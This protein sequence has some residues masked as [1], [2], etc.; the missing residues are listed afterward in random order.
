MSERVLL[1]TL[2]SECAR[3]LGL[4]EAEWQFHWDVLEAK[5]LLGK[6]LTFGCRE[7]GRG[8]YGL[9]GLDLDPTAEAIMIGVLG[10]I[11]YDI[12]KHGPGWLRKKDAWESLN[13]QIGEISESGRQLARRVLEWAQDNLDSFVRKPAH[14]PSTLQEGDQQ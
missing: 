2:C 11:V 5:D 12:L 13:Q 6:P 8:E 9:F 1:R 14:R 4:S 7:A 3:D 10:N